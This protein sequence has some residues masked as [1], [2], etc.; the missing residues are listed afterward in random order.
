VGDSE[1]AAEKNLNYEAAVRYLQARYGSGGVPVWLTPGETVAVARYASGGYIPYDRKLPVGR[2]ITTAVN[3]TGKSERVTSPDDLL[4][5]AGEPEPAMMLGSVTGYRWWTLPAPDWASWPALA[6]ETWPHGKLHGAQGDWFPGVN[7]AACQGGYY[8]TPDRVVHPAPAKGCGCG[9]WAYWQPERR[10]MGSYDVRVPV[11]G[12]IKAWGRTR[13]ATR[14]FRAE[15]ARILAVHLPFTLLPERKMREA[16]GIGW[17]DAFSSR[18][19]TPEFSPEEAQADAA[20]IE[21]WIAVI[22]D[23]LE[24]DYGVRVFETRDALLA[25]FPPDPVR[26]SRSCRYCGGDLVA[27]HPSWCCPASARGWT[28]RGGSGSVTT[29]HAAGGAG[30]AVYGGGGGGSSIS[31]PGGSGGSGGSGGGYGGHGGS[32]GSPGGS[33]GPGGGPGGSGSGVSRGLAQQSG[34]AGFQPPPKS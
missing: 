7:T 27:G 18:S 19:E 23:R 11:F 8:N 15:K 34:S 24:L 29:V 30:G 14:G 10:E 12:A 20:R 32:Y 31:F 17:Y 6:E 4:Q 9:Y 5:P 21:A 25:T 33:G 16:G 3:T 2:N 1:Y 13:L 22:G 28:A 26:G